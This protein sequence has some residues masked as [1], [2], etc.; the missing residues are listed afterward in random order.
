MSRGMTLQRASRVDWCLSLAVFFKGK[1]QNGE[2][3]SESSIENGLH[4]FH[5]TSK[6]S[7]EERQFLSNFNLTIVYTLL[8]GR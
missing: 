7:S 1:Q 8:R 2:G 5:E 4:L 6:N 3:V